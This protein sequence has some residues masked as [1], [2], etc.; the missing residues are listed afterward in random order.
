MHLLCD[1][2]AASRTGSKLASC[3]QPQSILGHRVSRAITQDYVV[4]GTI[5]MLNDVDVLYI[6]ITTTIKINIYIIYI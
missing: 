2:P 5:L 3:S 4:Y 6:S 1:G